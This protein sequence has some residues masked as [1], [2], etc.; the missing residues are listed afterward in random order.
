[1]TDNAC[2]SALDKKKERRIAK[3]A[4]KARREQYEKEEYER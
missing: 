3:R 4:E 2:S 1:M